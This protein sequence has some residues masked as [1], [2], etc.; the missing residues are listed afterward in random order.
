MQETRQHIIEILKDCEQ[1]T[2]DELVEKL[3]KRRGPITA[4][5]VRHHLAQLQKD[6]LIE[7]PELLHRSTP[8][9]PQHTYTLS[10]KANNFFPNNYQ[11]LLNTLLHQISY[12]MPPQ[13]VNVL[14]EGIANQMAQT[15][16]IPDLP[17]AQRLDL[18][19]EF[20][21]EQGYQA[22]WEEDKK[23]Y[24][25]HTTNCP[26]HQIA[27]KHTTLCEMDMRLVA[28]LTGVVPRLL[29]RVNAGDATCS[30]LIPIK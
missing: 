19:V 16:N 17:T 7:E 11:N 4:V 2:V 3:C 6:G 27:D 30:Y 26:Y 25:L 1:A 15:A 18:V 20:L 23:G 13:G 9:R 5:T 12:Q 8:G 29:T 22:Y 21:N 28:S 24:V 10:D 14:F